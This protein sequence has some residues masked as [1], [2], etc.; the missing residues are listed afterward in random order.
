MK[1]I[2]DKK[3]E[4]VVEY[5]DPLEG[6]K[7]WLVIDALSHKLCAGGVR[8][9]KGLTLDCVANL[10]RNM[11]LKMRI[12]GIRA[13][14]AKCGIDYDPHSPGKAEALQRFLR[15]ITPYMEER[16]SLG[17]D[18]NV[19]MQ[20]LDDIAHK[21]KIPSVKMPIAKAQG[22]DLQNFL[23]RYGILHNP[24]GNNHVTLSRLRAGVGLA[25]A[26]LGVLDFLRIPRQEATVAVQG[27]GS[28]GGAAAYSL[29]TSGV[30]IVGLADEEKSL[31]S[32]NE[33]SIDVRALLNG[34]GTGLIPR[35]LRDDQYLDRSR[36]YDVKCDVLI[37]AAIENSIVVDNARDISVKAIVPG[38]NLAITEEAEKLLHSRGIITIP[39]FVAGCGG[40]LSMDGLFGPKSHPSAQGVLDHVGKRMRFIVQKV[41]ERSHKDRITPREAALVLCSEAVI[42]PEARPYG[43]L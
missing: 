40:S 14:G 2:L 15:S 12:A 23:N 17:P 31:I 27:F 10:A 18:L 35:T 8:V 39:D 36:I 41:L 28:L 38:A 43:P 24:I 9:Q 26:C 22:F 5:T 30:K 7:G 6:F 32:H 3:P 16:Y 4:L 21:L 19:K 13:D 25:A 29:F 33:H 42:H 37:P 34:S 20:E 1:N 11:T